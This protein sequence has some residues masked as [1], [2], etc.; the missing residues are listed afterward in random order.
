MECI[1]VLIKMIFW[2][3]CK[4]TI[5]LALHTLHNQHRS[6]SDHMYKVDNTHDNN[7]SH[8]PSEDTDQLWHL[9]N[10]TRVFAVHVTKL[11]P[12]VSND[13]KAMIL[14]IYCQSNAQADLSHRYMRIRQCSFCV[15]VV[16]S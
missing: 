4:V 8:T 12:R 14:I 6:I 2:A 16:T 1:T 9:P 5:D 11:R 3:L 7:T 13:S 15:V 10:R